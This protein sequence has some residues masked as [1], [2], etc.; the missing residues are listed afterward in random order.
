[1]YGP[2]VS[3]TSVTIPIN[4]V[5]VETCEC[6]AIPAGLEVEYTRTL[7]P[8]LVRAC[9]SCCDGKET[10]SKLGPLTHDIVDSE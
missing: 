3:S 4:K 6:S 9:T 1:M 10:G 7:I 2:R 5:V 8:Y